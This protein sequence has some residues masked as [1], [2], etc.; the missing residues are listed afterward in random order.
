MERYINGLLLGLVLASCCLCSCSKDFLEAKPQKS[1]VIVKTLEDVAALLDNTEVMSRIDYFRILSDGDL[2]FTEAKLMASSEL[3]RNVYLW[4]ADYDPTKLNTT[5]WDLPYQ[6]I[7]Y[8]NIAL[9]TLDEIKSDVIKKPLYNEIK[10]RALFFRA[11]AHYQLLQDFAEAYDPQLPEQSGVPIILES[12]FPKQVK[13]ATL[14]E[15]YNAIVAD[16]E[17]AESLLPSTSILKTKPSRQAVYTLLSRVYLNIVDYPRSLSY[18][19][20][21]MDINKQLIDYNELIPTAAMPFNQYNYSTHPEIVFFASSNYPFV[22]AQGVEVE[23]ELYASYAVN[24]LRKHIF[25]NTAK[26]YV[27]TYSGMLYYQFTGLATDELYLSKAECL[28]RMDRVEEAITIMKAL[29]EKRFVDNVVTVAIP[30]SKDELL[31]WILLERRKELF[32][33]GTRWTDL[34]RLNRE[35]GLQADLQRNYQG[36]GFELPANSGRYVFFIPETDVVMSNLKQNIR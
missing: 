22:A 10:G 20:K 1:Q 30:Q 18:A 13:R 12:T 7:L 26:Q 27:G 8:A 19:E 5:T 24:D 33:R 32:G 23:Q 15:G 4:K 3:D 9:E 29:L 16:L 2:F 35:L 36:Q 6:Q 31:Q 21:A 34:K 14:R 17:A 11:W 25:F 28:V